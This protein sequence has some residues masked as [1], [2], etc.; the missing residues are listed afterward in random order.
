M[1]IYTLDA[2]GPGLGSGSFVA[3]SAD[4]IGNVTLKSGASVWF[5]A[6]IRGDNEE[7][8]IG[9]NSNIQDGSI[10]HADPGFPL[11]VGANVSVGH[12][13]MLHGCHIGDDCL[14]GIHSVILNG[15]RIG[16]NCVIGANALVA[17]GKVI[18]DGS[19]VLGSPGK[20]VR[21]IRPEE[22]RMISENA[23]DYAQRATRFE[24]GLHD[25]ASKESAA[26]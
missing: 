7:I 26:I 3:P 12:C 9:E 4:V 19:V 2:K 21:Q 23:R 14:I 1:T 8:I 16:K 5:N 6:V 17:E 22:M 13:A 11:V 20:I 15:A 24:R 25:A 10:L 18:P